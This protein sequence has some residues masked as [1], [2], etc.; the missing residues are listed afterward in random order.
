MV[1][2]SSSHLLI[3]RT[4]YPNTVPAAD[5]EHPLEVLAQSRAGAWE[6]CQR[7]YL[8]GGSKIAIAP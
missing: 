4:M 7:V 8:P 5:Q 3:A 1:V 2:T 6:V